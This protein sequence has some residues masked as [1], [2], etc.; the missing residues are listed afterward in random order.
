MDSGFDVMGIV[1]CL[2]NIF[3]KAKLIKVITNTRLAEGK[4]VGPHVM[5]MTSYFRQ[6]EKLE[7]TFTI[8]VAQ[9]FIFNSLPSN[10]LGFVMNYRMQ[11]MDKS[12][13]ELQG[14]L[15]TAEEELKKDKGTK[16]VLAVSDKGKKVKKKTHRSIKGKG[17]VKPQA[18]GAPEGSKK[19]KN[20]TTSEIVC[21]YCD[22]KG[23]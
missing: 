12:L 5:K 21:Y 13:D 10:Y 23:H 9:D 16:E 8:G 17:K 1:D 6:L 22:K 4:E 3:E 11:R 20:P 7:V 18:K 19:K 15:T 14:M 2:K